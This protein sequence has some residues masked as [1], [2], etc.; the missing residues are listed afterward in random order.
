MRLV[1]CCPRRFRSQFCGFE[2]SS[3]FDVPLCATYILKAAQ[4]EPFD[5]Q[6]S[7]IVNVL[8]LSNI[9]PKLSVTTQCCICPFAEI[10]NYDKTIFL[11]RI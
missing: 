7:P 8:A 2:F 6:Q 11:K 10:E 3:N 9:W 5:S 4:F 1:A